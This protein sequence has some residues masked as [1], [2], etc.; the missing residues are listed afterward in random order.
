VALIKRQKRPKLT[1]ALPARQVICGNC[2]SPLFADDSPGGD[3]P[4]YCCLGCRSTWPPTDADKESLVRRQAEH[5]LRMEQR[6]KEARDRLE[7]GQPAIWVRKSKMTPNQK[8]KVRIQARMEEILAKPPDA[9][10]KREWKWLAEVWEFLTRGSRGGRKRESKYEEWLAKGA[11][12]EVSGTRRPLFRNLAGKNLTESQVQGQFKDEMD[13][14][15][16]AFKKARKRRQ[17]P[18]PPMR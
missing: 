10:T 2:G 9:I 15:R 11:R 12:A 16:D 4:A 17:L 13:K 5:A 6:N 18:I 14:L 8:R 7:R 3:I 1:P